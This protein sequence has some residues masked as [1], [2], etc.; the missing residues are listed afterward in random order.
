SPTAKEISVPE[1]GGYK[2]VLEILLKKDPEQRASAETTLKLLK[3]HSIYGAII[4][5]LEE[6]FYR[7][8]DVCHIKISDD[9][10]QELNNK[11]PVRLAVEGMGEQRRSNAAQAMTTANITHAAAKL[12]ISSEI[13]RTEC[14]YGADCYRD[15][16][17]HRQQYSH[18]GDADYSG[19]LTSYSSTAHQKGATGYTEY[20]THKQKPLCPYGAN[21]Y[22]KNEE[23]R[24]DYRH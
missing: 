21:C 9:I 20:S 12:S 15:T 22:R 18:P 16:Q 2:A 1:G 5:T 10:R 19:V 17:T 3:Q 11:K 6:K 24:R 8:D 14:R 4:K 23:H 7:V 13:K